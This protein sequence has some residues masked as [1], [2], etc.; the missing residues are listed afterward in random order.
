MKSYLDK[1]S[2]D[3]NSD[4][5]VR[6]SG[7]KL[8]EKLLE[9]ICENRCSCQYVSTL[10]GRGAEIWCIMSVCRPWNHIGVL[11]KD[12]STYVTAGYSRPADH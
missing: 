4:K 7:A 5:D 12:G 2:R 6:G 10:V 1:L 11:C 9:R 3:I 8:S